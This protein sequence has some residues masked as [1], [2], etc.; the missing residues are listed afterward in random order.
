MADLLLSPTSTDL[1]ERLVAKAALEAAEEQLRSLCAAHAT[2][3]VAV[4]RRGAALASSLKELQEKI[5]K[6]EP[7]V[8]N[9]KR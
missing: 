9:V 2:T 6:I 1:D 4:E 5:K 3:F 8:A 7:E